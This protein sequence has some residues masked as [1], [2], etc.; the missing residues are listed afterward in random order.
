MTWVGHDVVCA[1]FIIELV[2]AADEISLDDLTADDE[3]LQ[4]HKISKHKGII[5]VITYIQQQMYVRQSTLPN[6]G[7]MVKHKLFDAD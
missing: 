6:K 4:N 5:L 7:P 3:D 1:H 2:T